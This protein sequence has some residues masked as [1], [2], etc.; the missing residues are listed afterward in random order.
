MDKDFRIS[1]DQAQELHFSRFK[2]VGSD[3]A[4]VFKTISKDV[5][6]VYILYNWQC[7]KASVFNKSQRFQRGGWR[8]SALSK[9]P[10]VQ[11]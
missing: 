1:Q 5:R 11:V 4:Y 3:T 9:V 6:M 10:V 7:T 2:S 8:D